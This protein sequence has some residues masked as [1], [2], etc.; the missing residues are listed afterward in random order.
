MW[1][2]RNNAC[3]DPRLEY[4]DAN[5]KGIIDTLVDYDYIIALC[6]FATQMHL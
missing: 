2:G 1:L 6:H 5:K 3:I 4:K